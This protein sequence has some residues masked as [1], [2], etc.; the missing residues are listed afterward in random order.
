MLPE[1]RYSL[2]ALRVCIAHSPPAFPP[3]R[4]QAGAGA[5][6]AV[7]QP[8]LHFGSWCTFEAERGPPT[9]TKWWH[10]FGKKA[11]ACAREAPALVRSDKKQRS[12]L[13]S[14]HL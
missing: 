9:S 6:G 5:A 3:A 11:R 7:F 8:L 14:D 10:V 1:T 2:F 13:V 4:R 12:D